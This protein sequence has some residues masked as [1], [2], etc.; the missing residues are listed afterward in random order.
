MNEIFGIQKRFDY[1]REQYPDF[2]DYRDGFEQILNSLAML[3][4]QVL[5][6]HPEENFMR[7]ACEKTAAL[8]LRF[9]IQFC[10]EERHAKT[11]MN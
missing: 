9:M 3:K 11:A 1:I 8:C 10:R 5:N 2:D 6:E 7:N 4:Q